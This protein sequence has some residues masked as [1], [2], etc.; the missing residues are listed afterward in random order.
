MRFGISSNFRLLREITLENRRIQ[1][2]QK[3]NKKIIEGFL[4]LHHF[5]RLIM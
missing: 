3:R 5:V 2:H 1:E 4:D